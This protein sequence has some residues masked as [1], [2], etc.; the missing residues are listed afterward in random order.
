MRF[1]T[2][3]IPIAALVAVHWLVA[4]AADE[5]T[6]GAAVKDDRGIV[7]HSIHSV[8]QSGTTDVRILLPD[9][10]APNRHYPVIYLLP[11]EAGHGEHYG[12]S[13]AEVTKLGLHKRY[14]AIFVAPTFSHLPWYADHPTDPAIRQESYLLNVVLPLVER[15]YPAIDKPKGRLLLGF[16]KSGWGAWSLLLRHPDVFGRAA[17][18]DA[19][20]AME[21]VGRFGSEGVFGTQANFEKYRIADLLRAR[22]GELGNSE[23][24]VLL[25]YHGFA[26]DLRQTHALLDALKV[27]HVYRDGPERKH[28]W[29]GGWLAEAV[30]LLV[31]QPAADKP[32]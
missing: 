28:D 21:R 5:A 16:S 24:L 31:E 8:Y 30:E 18:W 2:K 26:A 11:V 3:S 27:P 6:F 29:H 4:A 17:A 20:L 1:F 32:N 22:G 13:M 7:T 12:D 9:D 19:P 23:R 25:G 15:A 10:L 14:G